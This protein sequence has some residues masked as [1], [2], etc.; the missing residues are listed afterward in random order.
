MNYEDPT[1]ITKKQTAKSQSEEKGKSE[2]PSLRGR[3][4]QSGSRE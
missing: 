1:G 3:G 4:S 2:D